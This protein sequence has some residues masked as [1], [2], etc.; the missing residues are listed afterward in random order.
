MY[1]L[2]PRVQSFM[3]VALQLIPFSQDIDSNE[4]APHPKR[5]FMSHTLAMDVVES[6]M[7]F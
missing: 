4:I 2:S 7:S 6:S 5:R 3:Y 1:M